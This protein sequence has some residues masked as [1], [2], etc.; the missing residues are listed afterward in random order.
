M[1][2]AVKDGAL[3]PYT[4]N[5][6]LYKCPNALFGEWRTYSVVDAMNADN[7]DAP[8]EMM[9]KHRT[10]ILKPAYRCVFVDDSGATPMG[11]WS[12]YYTRPAWR[13]EPP[14]RHGDG[15]TWGFSDGHSEYWKWQDLLT[16]TYNNFNTGIWKAIDFP[17]SLDIPKAQRAV[18][19]EL[20][21]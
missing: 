16:H 1:I 6:R 3:F 13:D 20:G 18:W 11:G 19:G 15:G 2:Q 5:V 8:P 10:E 7:I 4:K 17:N 12:I 21:Y 14:V 9:L